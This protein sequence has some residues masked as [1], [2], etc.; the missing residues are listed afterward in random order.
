MTATPRHLLVTGA[1]GFVGRH[2]VHDAVA[3]GWR[4]RAATRRGGT[5]AGGT[6]V[7]VG[8][9]DGETDW[10]AALEGITHI[11]HLAGRSQSRDAENADPDA[12][13]RV[14]VDGVRRLAEAARAEGVEQI[15]LVSSIAVYDPDLTHVAPNTRTEPGTAY[16]TSRLAGEEALAAA[17]GAGM[18]TTILR[19]PMIYGPGAT[20]GFAWLA[21]LAAGR[22]PLPL[23]SVRNRRSLVYVRNLTDAILTALEHERAAGRT[24]LVSDGE[25]VSTPFLLSRLAAG[26]GRPP[27]LWRLPPQFVA[28]AARLAGKKAAWRALAGSR[29]LDATDL[30]FVLGW[31]PPHRP[32]EALAESARW[33]RAERFGPDGASP[34]PDMATRE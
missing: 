6:A 25:D 34:P 11:V 31:I 14:N 33:F 18:A 10:H 16:G 4:V 26:M 29:T 15:V 20:G 12:L 19:A 9:I 2:M 5:V 7:A 32:V 3:A 30:G 27:R 22:W 8:D 1:D 23:A 13:T 21:A 28:A 17:A 24:F